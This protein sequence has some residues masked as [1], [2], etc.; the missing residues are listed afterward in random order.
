YNRLRENPTLGMW[1]RTFLFAGKAAPA[2][3]LAKLVI[4]LL[5]NLAVTIDDDPAVRGRLKVVFLPEYSVSGR[6]ADSRLR[7]VKPDLHRRLR[8]QRH[9]QHEVHDERRADDRDTRRR[10]D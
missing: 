1:P 4:K 8:G 2:Y 9:E 6:A 7:R 3:H 10:D 5:N